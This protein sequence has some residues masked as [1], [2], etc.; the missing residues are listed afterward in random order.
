[1]LTSFTALEE[2]SLKNS[3]QEFKSSGYF[4]EQILSSKTDTRRNG[5]IKTGEYL[6][7]F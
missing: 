1:M 6:L 4:E 7:C 2:H 5:K 3:L